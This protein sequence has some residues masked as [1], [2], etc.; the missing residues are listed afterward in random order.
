LLRRSPLVFLPV[1]FK[2]EFEFELDP[3]F[4]LGGPVF[5]GELLQPE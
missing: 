1:E 4:G 2:E 3:A 5:F